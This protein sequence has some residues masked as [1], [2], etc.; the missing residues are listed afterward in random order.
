MKQELK[1]KTMKYIQKIIMPTLLG[2]AILLTACGDDPV[3]TSDLLDVNDVTASGSD[4]EVRMR[5]TSNASWTV[6]ENVDWITAVKPAQGSGDAEVVL[7][8]QSNPYADTDSIRV[9]NVVVET[10][11]HVKRTVKVS[12]LPIEGSLPI[13]ADVK[14]QE[15]ERNRCTVS[16]TLASPLLVSETGLCYSTTD[17]APTVS[18]DHMA[19]SGAWHN[20]DLI[21]ELTELESGM[22]YFVRPYAV[23]SLGTAY[24]D[25]L[26]ITTPG[27]KPSENENNWPT[28]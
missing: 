2:A 23:S 12:Q 4:T 20:A 5:I 18:G 13:L 22:E 26:Q 15:V 17:E 8:L 7:Y 10:T 21:L 11:G 19:M 9:G 24:G 16:F 14:I 25:A 3:S 27:D 6:T 1:M 28:W